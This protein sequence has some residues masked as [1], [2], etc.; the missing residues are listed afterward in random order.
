M[1]RKKSLVLT[2]HELRL[3]E[4]LW[5]N[6]RATVAEVTAALSPPSLAYNTVL[7]TM[8]TLEQKGYVTHEELGRAYA[9]RPLFKRNDAARSAVKHVRDADRDQIRQ[10]LARKAKARP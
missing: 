1:P 10:L 5:E 9:Y 8:R 4:V 2:D 6:G 7:S 3:M